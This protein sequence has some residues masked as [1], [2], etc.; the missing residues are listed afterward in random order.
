MLIDTIGLSVDR[1]G[2]IP[3]SQYHFTGIITA[4]F[5]H[6]SWS[7]LGGN[8]VGLLICGYLASRLPNFKTASLGI[9]LLTGLFVWLF[10]A[11]G[12]HIGASGVVMGYYGYLVGVALFQ[13][14]LLSVL[15]LVVLALATYYANINF[16]GTLFDFSD[17]VSSESHLFGFV[18][19]VLVAFLLRSNSSKSLSK[20][21]T[22][23]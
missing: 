23:K 19:G 6:D 17:N 1:L 8:L 12:N 4:P 16:I 21:S 15:S 11:G 10:A 18:S 22:G 3:H 7:H 9:I 14:N 2:I 20:L 5:V 13:R